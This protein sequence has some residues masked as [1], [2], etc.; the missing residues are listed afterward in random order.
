[1]KA[2][3]PNNPT[4]TYAAYRLTHRDAGRRRSRR[5]AQ[6]MS[7][8]EALARLFVA[9]ATTLVMLVVIGVALFSLFIG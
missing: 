4:S 6:P 9:S 5:S 7:P 3:N 8:V 2:W 1:M